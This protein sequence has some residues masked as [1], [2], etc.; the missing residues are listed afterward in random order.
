MKVTAP[1]WPRGVR[2]CSRAP[3]EAGEESPEEG[4]EHLAGEPGVVGAAVAKRVGQ[5]EDPLPDR[6]LGQD[7][8]D[9]VRRGVGHAPAAARGAEAAPLAG[10]GDEALQS[11]RIAAEPQEAVGEDPA[12][13][14]R[15]QLLLDEAGH[16]TIAL[17]GAGEEALELLA[18]DC[19]Q[20]RLLGAVP[21][22]ARRGGGRGAGEGAIGGGRGSHARSGLRGPCRPWTYFSGAVARRR[23]PE[24]D[25][26]SLRGTFARFTCAGW[27][28]TSA[29]G[30]ACREC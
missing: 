15:A 23:R 1:H 2:Q 25:G 17:P 9:E 29:P 4:A 12:A 10:E 24:G 5:R 7:A 8:V 30:L 11:A 3:A 13:K 16:R 22:V 20:L 19:V 21:F 14:V 28:G 27:C 26:R 6:H 18:N